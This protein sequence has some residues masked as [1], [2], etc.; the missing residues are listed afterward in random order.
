LLNERD[1]FGESGSKSSQQFV[2]E[3]GSV[4]SGVNGHQYLPFP[5]DMTSFIRANGKAVNGHG[6]PSEQTAQNAQNGHKYASEDL[7]KKAAS[8]N[9][10][11]NL[12]K[13]SVCHLT[14]FRSN[15]VSPDKSGVSKVLFGSEIG[16]SLLVIVFSI[17]ITFVSSHKFVLINYPV[18]TISRFLLT[19]WP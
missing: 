15:L 6:Q 3:S 13:C 5:M 16:N 12:E 4:A 2:S 11:V 10:K 14:Y 8:F 1:D 17:T 18:F 7:K 9:N 19:N